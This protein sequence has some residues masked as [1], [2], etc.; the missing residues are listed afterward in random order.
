MTGLSFIAVATT[1]EIAEKAPSCF[2]VEG[3]AVVVCRL[4]DEYF[5]FENRCSHALST[6][7]NGRLRGYRLICPL[8][9]AAFDIRDGSALGPPAKRPLRS[10]PLRI[11]GNMIE[12]DISA[13]ELSAT[14]P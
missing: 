6:F 12:I 3:T 11:A 7:D 10:L 1:N 8:H 9:G 2:M 13:S 4:K 14:K 5:A